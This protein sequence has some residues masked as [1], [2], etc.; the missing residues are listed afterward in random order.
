MLLL[1]TQNQYAHIGVQ[2]LDHISEQQSDVALKTHVTR[3]FPEAKLPKQPLDREREFVSATC[4]PLARDRESLAEDQRQ[5]KSSGH[6]HRSPLGIRR[7]E[8]CQHR[9]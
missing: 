8:R 7:A 6:P 9:F 2:G 4:N 1:R 3:R 5:Q